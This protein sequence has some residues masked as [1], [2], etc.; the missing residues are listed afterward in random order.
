MRHD[1]GSAQ[2]P[3]PAQY[4]NVTLDRTD[5]APSGTGVTVT[6]AGSG[7]P[8]PMRCTFPPFPGFLS[9]FFPGRGGRPQAFGLTADSRPSGSVV[10]G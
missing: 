7:R 4:A 9:G 8:T 5:L 3:L 10:R 1:P 2:P 6:V